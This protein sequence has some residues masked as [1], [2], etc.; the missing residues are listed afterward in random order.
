[1]GLSEN[2]IDERRVFN[3]LQIYQNEQVNGAGFTLEEIQH[4]AEP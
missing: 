2:R 1:M 4:C 3:S